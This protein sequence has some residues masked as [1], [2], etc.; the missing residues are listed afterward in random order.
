MS[1]VRSPLEAL[2][3]DAPT[4]VAV[5]EAQRGQDVTQIEALAHALVACLCAA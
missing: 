4:P 2:V 3:A 1:A 5:I